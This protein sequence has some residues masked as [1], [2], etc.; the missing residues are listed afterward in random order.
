MSIKI[1]KRTWK[2]YFVRW[3]ETRE[4]CVLKR[5]IYTQTVKLLWTCNQKK[6]S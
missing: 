4:N 2:K 6:Q 5:K 1:L 3:Q